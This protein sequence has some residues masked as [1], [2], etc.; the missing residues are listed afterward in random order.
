[1]AEKKTRPKMCMTLRN[2]SREGILWG[3]N[4][5]FTG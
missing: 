2:N 3:Q 4:V 5:D 1:M